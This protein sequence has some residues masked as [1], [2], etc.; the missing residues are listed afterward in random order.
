MKIPYEEPLA[1]G[2][3]VIALAPDIIAAIL[4]TLQAGWVYASARADVHAEAGEVTV[5]EHLRDGM[6][7]ALNGLNWGKTMIILP[8]TESRSRPEVLLPDGRTDIPIL[9]IE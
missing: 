1:I 9:L 2:R 4:V 3:E 8:G 5:T 6:R 7:R